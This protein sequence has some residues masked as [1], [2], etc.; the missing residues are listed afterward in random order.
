MLMSLCP[1]FLFAP[2]YY[3]VNNSEGSQDLHTWQ[4][5]NRKVPKM[6]VSPAQRIDSKA[7]FRAEIDC[8]S[9]RECW[10]GVPRS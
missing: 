7:E 3:F 2:E 1:N 5:Q 4:T 6:Q 8:A 9:S 10:C